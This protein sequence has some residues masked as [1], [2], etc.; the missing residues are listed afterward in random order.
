[1]ASP[2]QINSLILDQLARGEK[3]VLGLVV[4]VRQGLHSENFKG[5]L[6]QTVKAALRKLVASRVV[7]E[8]DGMFSLVP[9]K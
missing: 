9:Q 1:M 4:A 5:D 3:R 7:A 8:A 2:L 6:S